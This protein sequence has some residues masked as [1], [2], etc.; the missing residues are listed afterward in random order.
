MLST[1]VSGWFSTNVPGYRDMSEEERAQIESFSI[2]WSLFEAP[3]LAN[4]ASCSC[5][6][7]QDQ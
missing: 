7:S 4:S 5:D 2:L 6:S 1:D 3:V